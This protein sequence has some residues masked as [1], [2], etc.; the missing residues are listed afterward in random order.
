M[1]INPQFQVVTRMQVERDSACP[2]KAMFKK[3]FGL[4]KE[5]SKY[6]SIG[7]FFLWGISMSTLSGSLETLWSIPVLL[8]T[9]SVSALGIYFGILKDRSGKRGVLGIALN[10]LG[11]IYNLSIDMLFLML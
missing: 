2:P 5:K 1:V 6:T 8:L 3:I 11:M 4:S 7:L 9:H 10:I